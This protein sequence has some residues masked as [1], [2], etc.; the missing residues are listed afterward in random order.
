MIGM[1]G[2]IASA[3]AACLLLGVSGGAPQPVDDEKPLSETERA[4][5][6]RLRAEV[7]KL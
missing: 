5:L 2:R 4:E 7:R 3:A 6:Q 1:Q